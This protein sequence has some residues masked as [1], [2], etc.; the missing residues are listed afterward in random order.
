MPK[1]AMIAY[2]I[3]ALLVSLDNLENKIN[4]NELINDEGYIGLRGL[5]RLKKNGTVERTFQLK[6]IKIKNLRY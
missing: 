1:I 2:D 4:I 6:K 3:T 5:F